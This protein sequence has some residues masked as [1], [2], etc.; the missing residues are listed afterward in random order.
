VNLN[1]FLVY[2]D[3]G[4]YFA[5]FFL[6]NMIV[7]RGL[8]IMSMIWHLVTGFP[9]KDVGIGEDVVVFV[10]DEEVDFVLSTNIL[11]NLVGYC[12]QNFIMLIGRIFIS[13]VT[14]TDFLVLFT[15]LFVVYLAVFEDQVV[16]KVVDDEISSAYR[17]PED[18]VELTE[19]NQFFGNCF[20]EYFGTDVDSNS[21]S[22]WR[23]VAIDFDLVSNADSTELVNDDLASNYTVDDFISEQ[24]DIV[25]E[26]EP[27][28]FFGNCFE[29]YFGTD[30]DSN[31]SSLWRRIV[32]DLDLVSDIDS[33]EDVDDDDE[34]SNF[35]GDENLVNDNSRNECGASEKDNIEVN[36]EIGEWIS[37]PIY[38]RNNGIVNNIPYT[39]E[40][41]FNAFIDRLARIKVTNV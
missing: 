35:G 9:W 20:N 26:V 10:M 2:C 23:R 16:E 1:I 4:R 31:C 22:L 40:S 6:V 12:Y 29:E 41:T 8:L 37:H 21:S 38:W 25:D 32:K 39:Y 36:R 24:E 33:T 34:A 3:F 15:V 18:T 28:G 27:K 13:L 17:D 7:V 5:E 11:V 19:P 14:F 30:V